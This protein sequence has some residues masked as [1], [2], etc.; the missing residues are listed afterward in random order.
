MV[1]L[2]KLQGDSDK[3]DTQIRNIFNDGIIIPPNSKIGL[4]SCRVNF[5]N[6]QDFENF[7]LPTD[8]T[9]EVDYHVGDVPPSFLQK[10]VVPAKD[11][12]GNVIEYES[13]GQLLTALS[14]Q[15]N[16]TY[17]D[18]SIVRQFVKYQGFHNIWDLTTGTLDAG[19]SEFLTYSLPDQNMAFAAPN[20]QFVKQS[21]DS[22]TSVSLLNGAIGITASTASPLADDLNVE[23]LLSIPLVNTVMSGEIDTLPANDPA[24]G[25]DCFVFAAKKG[26]GELSSH[27]ALWGWGISKDHNAD[28]SYAMWVNNE[29]YFFPD[30]TPLRT[31][32][33]V[34]QTE[35]QIECR[36]LGDR[37]R[38]DVKRGGSGLPLALAAAPVASTATS[39]QLTLTVPTGSGAHTGNQVILSDFVDIGRP[40]QALA[41]DGVATSNSPTV[42]IASN[43]V[44]VT[45]AQADPIVTV[46][47]AV[48]ELPV[49]GDAFTL[50]GIKGFEANLIA[51]GGVE[52]TQI[53]A[54]PSVKV[55]TATAHNLVAGDTFT[56]SGVTQ[57]I[58]AGPA[59]IGGIPIAD[60]NGVTF[61]VA[62]SPAPTATELHYVMTGKTS[63][64][65]AVSG[66]GGKLNHTIIGGLPI[67]DFN[68]FSGTVLASPAP[69][70]TEFSFTLTGKTSTVV[71][72]GGGVDGQVT[73]VPNSLPLTLTFASDHYLLTGETFT[74]IPSV[75][76]DG[77]AI[78]AGTLHTV[79]SVPSATTI[80]IAMPSGQRAVTGGIT[81][82]G[83]AMTI[84]AST[85]LI[86]ATFLNATHTITAVPTAT[87]I[88][89]AASDTVNF[90]QT[91][92]GSSAKAV[93][94]SNSIGVMLSG[95]T[96]QNAQSGTIPVLT[97]DSLDPQVVRWQVTADKACGFKVDSLTY[98]ASGSFGQAAGVGLTINTTLTFPRNNPIGSYIGFTDSVYNNIGGPSV[99][100]SDQPAIGRNA[101]PAILVQSLKGLNL[102]SYAGVQDAPNKPISFFDV[103][104]PQSVSTISNMIYE[105][106]NLA[107]LDLH[108]ARPIELKDLS[109]QFA[110]DDT[111]K[112]LQFFGNPT[113][114]LELEEGKE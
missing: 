56:M 86:S 89:I 1:K 12:S 93:F 98:Q 16:A 59:T 107:M 57:T 84:Q 40:T 73:G 62:A 31:D 28:R 102:N 76:V 105:P 43:G 78:G 111:G 104:V 3:S 75:A 83:A 27:P 54:D 101:Y 22:D 65:A 79:A 50:G 61:T 19:R 55:T 5:L 92:G 51:A 96:S 63:S 9:I 69:T 74:M 23:G 67:S 106:N 110:R 112:P 47:T 32:K 13:A 25:D 72:T 85:G 68:G 34:P 100:T 11:G 108:N 82:G 38:F 53:Q 77:V 48:A 103:I 66:N 2:I 26:S 49:A 41:N 58:P 64:D 20:N 30:S 70:T 10:V 91:G 36:K 99:I 17:T 39:D 14:K 109:I 4:R 29:K 60:F 90:T 88:T 15:S 71:S 80:T 94:A 35:D 8:T 18:E 7:T 114:V 44:S 52:V 95:S 6:I 45:Q 87:T 24:A 21:P 113:V 97:S 42:N 33:I 37:V 81:G 46:T